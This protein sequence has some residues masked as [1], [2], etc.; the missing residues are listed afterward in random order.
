MKGYQQRATLRAKV[1]IVF[2]WRVAMKKLEL[3]LY[4]LPILILLVALAASPW[5]ALFYLV[6]GL[7]AQTIGLLHLVALAYVA[8]LLGL[9]A[10]VSPIFGKNET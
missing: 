1:A 4:G 5:L 10:A 2:F 7:L 6:H 3:L 9:L 8:M